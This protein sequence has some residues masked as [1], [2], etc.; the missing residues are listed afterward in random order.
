MCRGLGS[1]A[2]DPDHEPARVFW[3]HKLSNHL[4]AKIDTTI[5]QATE[6]PGVLARHVARSAAQPID[7]HRCR[8]GDVVALAS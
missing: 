4:A 8:I 2:S 6:E 3:Q 1:V 7:D 5:D